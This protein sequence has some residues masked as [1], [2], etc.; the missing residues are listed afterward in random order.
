LIVFGIIALLIGIPAGICYGIFELYKCCVN[1]SNNSSTNTGESLE[2]LES[3]ESTGI[4]DSSDE[5]TIELPHVV[6]TMPV[7]SSAQ[8][9]NKIQTPKY[10]KI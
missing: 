1:R 8:S 7:E 2:S 10:V 9:V 6:Q 5:V 4:V 3:T